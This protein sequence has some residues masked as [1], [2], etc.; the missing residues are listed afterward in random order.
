MTKPAPFIGSSPEGPDFARAVRALEE[1]GAFL[2][3][4][5]ENVADHR[6]RQGSGQVR[7]I[8]RRAASA[9]HFGGGL[10]SGLGEAGGGEHLLAGRTPHELDQF[11]CQFR[12]LGPVEHGDG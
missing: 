2:G 5:A 6:H 9:V 11:A 7:I 1:L 4:H 10:W 12:I 8:A 3:Q